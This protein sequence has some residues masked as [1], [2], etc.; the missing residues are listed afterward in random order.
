MEQGCVLFL[1][2][3]LEKMGEWCVNWILGTGNVR[4][5]TV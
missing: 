5:E 4:I 2:W 3:R 1:G